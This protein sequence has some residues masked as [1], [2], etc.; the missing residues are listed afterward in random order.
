MS[1]LSERR[2]RLAAQLAGT[3][4]YEEL[5]AIGSEIAEVES[6]LLAAEHRWLT[7]AEG[8]ETER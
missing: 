5:A 4:A 6:L 8:A 7:L 3:T 2:D 1:K